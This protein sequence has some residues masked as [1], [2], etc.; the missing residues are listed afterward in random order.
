MAR[1][2]LPILALF[3]ST[4]FL[5]AGGGVHAILLPVRAQIEGFST[6]E[7]GLIGAGWAVGFTAGCLIVPR[8]VRRVGHVRTFSSLCAMLAIAMLANGLI[9][10]PFTWIGLRAVAGLC[11]SG[12]YMVIESWLNERMTNENRGT[13]FSVYM[14]VS[15][16]AMLGGQYVL[17]AAPPERETLFM[18][19]A[20]LYALAVLPTALSR[21]QS[22]A[23][24]TQVEFDISKLYRNSPAAVVCAVLAGVISSAWMSFAPVFAKQVGMSNANIANVLALAMIGSVAMQMPIGRLSDR[25]DRRWVMIGSSLA[26]ALAGFLIAGYPVNGA[27]PDLMFFAGVVLFGGFIFPIYSLVVAHANDYAAAEDFVQTASGLLI[28]YGAGTMI[29]PLVTAEVMDLLGPAGLFTVIGGAHLAIAS[30][31]SYRILRRARPEDLETVDFQTV[32][33]T[34]AETPETWALDPRSTLDGEE[35]GAG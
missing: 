34:R 33:L 1:Q 11:F 32:P 23:P 27:S 16:V 29:G 25:M 21:A 8:L 14:V 9:V 17:V 19:G 4:A 15:Q 28:L 7:I 10:E 31:V 13:I 12:S 18:I 20:I 35:E 5:M 22:P 2:L 26:G 30:F 24:L 3:A 6:T